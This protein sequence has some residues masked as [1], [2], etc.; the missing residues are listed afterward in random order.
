MLACRVHLQH[1]GH[2]IANDSQY[3][4]AL[5]DPSIPLTSRLQVQTLPAASQSTSHSPTQ[6]DQSPSETALQQYPPQ[7][8]IPPM[9]APVASDDPAQPSMPT[10][11][12]QPG[13][14]L[15]LDEPAG[16]PSGLS[17]ADR[18]PEQGQTQLPARKKPCLAEARI[19]GGGTGAPAQQSQ[20]LPDSVHGG[21]PANAA[22][23]GI[24]Q[25]DKISRL[26]SPSLPL[27]C[28][29]CHMPNPAGLA[30]AS[31]GD[32]P[33]ALG[34]SS[35][36]QDA[37]AGR[38]QAHEVPEASADECGTG[39]KDS[40]RP[41]SGGAGPACAGLDTAAVD[42]SGVSARISA[43]SGFSQNDQQAH[44]ASSERHS[45]DDKTGA[46]TAELVSMEVRDH[47]GVP[48]HEADGRTGTLASPEALDVR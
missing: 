24:G 41:E 32:G 30:S 48:S 17:T 25:P 23:D 45:G 29:A 37:H 10:H 22:A 34:R 6:P 1:S 28:T 47:A 15:P 42:V 46:D 16:H 3:G 39:F 11:G 18:T 13:H 33:A 14:S 7:R 40:A 2:P 20:R 12:M 31:T 8:Q 5:G 4:G 35:S 38:G 9:D 44:P 36:A 26:N 21:Y 19:R 27:D 43:C